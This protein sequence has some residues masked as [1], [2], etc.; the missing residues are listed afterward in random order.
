MTKIN[1]NATEL[2]TLLDYFMSDLGS[3]FIDYMVNTEGDLYIL[4][5]GGI[6]QNELLFALDNRDYF[7]QYIE[8]TIEHLHGLKNSINKV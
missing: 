8:N 4:R 7:R 1:T 3:C 6:E 5:V 2:A